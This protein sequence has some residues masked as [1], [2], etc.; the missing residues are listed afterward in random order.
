MGNGLQG[1]LRLALPTYA[2]KPFAFG[3][4][5]WRHYSLANNDFN[6]SA[7]ANSDDV[8]EIPVGLGLGWEYAGFTLDARGEYRW[9]FSDN[10]VPLL[11]VDGTTEDANMNRWGVNANIGYMF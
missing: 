10:M 7:I 3:G 2:V 11:T 1:N 6:T 9:S 5:A 8:G 4:I